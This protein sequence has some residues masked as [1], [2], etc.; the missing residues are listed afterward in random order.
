MEILSEDDSTPKFHLANLSEIALVHT[1]EEEKAQNPLE[2]GLWHQSPIGSRSKTASL[3]ELAQ[4]HAS[5]PP[6]VDIARPSRASQS[7]T[8]W[9]QKGI[10]LR[11]SLIRPTSSMP[12]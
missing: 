10:S 4:Y 11:I 7:I 8:S 9:V 3:P 12:V 1:A 6:I 2:E 5:I